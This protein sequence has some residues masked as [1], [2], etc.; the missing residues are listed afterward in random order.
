VQYHQGSRHFG[1]DPQIQAIIEQCGIEQCPTR[2]IE[3]GQGHQM[4]GDK[5]RI[6]SNKLT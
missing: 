5:C 2:V 1:A 6:D 3:I 4:R